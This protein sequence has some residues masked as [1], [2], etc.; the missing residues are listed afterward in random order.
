MDSGT[1]SGFGVGVAGGS[2]LASGQQGQGIVALLV[3][4]AVLCIIFIYC[5]WGA[6]FCRSLCRRHCCCRLEDPECDSRLENSEQTMV[7]TPTIILLPHGRMLVVDGTIFTQFQ[8]DSTGLDL[9]ELGEN[10]IRAQ[11]N[12]RCVDRHQLQSSQGS[13]LEMDAETPS[14]DSMGSVG[15]FPPPTYESIYGKDGRE[16]PP[17]YSDILLH[18]F[19][20]LPY[21][22]ELQDS[23]TNN[24]EDIEMHSLDGCPHII[25][26]PMSNMAYHPYATVTSFSSRSFPRSNISRN[27]SVIINPVDNF[28][29][30]NELGSVY[31]I[32]QGNIALSDSRRN[33]SNQ[34][35]ILHSNVNALNILQNSLEGRPSEENIDIIGVHDNIGD[36]IESNLMDNRNLSFPNVTMRNGEIGG[37]IV[38]ADRRRVDLDGRTSRQAMRPDEID[39]RIHHEEDDN[40]FEALADIRESRV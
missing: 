11:R 31:A 7:A 24:K 37:E 35:I 6:P 34:E 15:C 25:N 21:E 20:N 38:S 19:A 28:Y 29:I 40:D 27:S 12:P 22:I 17:S 9:V 33:I 10:V 36:A 1:I 26:N 39:H 14:K 16:M 23:C 32:N 2:S 5:C 18:R 4:L 30:T 3:M 13:I 8:G